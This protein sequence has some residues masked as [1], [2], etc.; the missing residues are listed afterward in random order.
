[1]TSYKPPPSRWKADSALAIVALVWGSTF[2]IVKHAL[3]DIS[4]M[5]FLALRFALAA[6]CML[7]IFARPFQRATQGAVLRGLRGGA[8]AGIFLWL[9]YVLQTVGLK[10]TTAGNSGFL[11]GLYIVLV[12]LIS[13]AVYRRW[14]QPRE[15][16]GIAIATGGMAVLT[17]PSAGHTFQLNRGD[18]LTLGCAV[19]FAFHL[20]VLGYYSQ[21]ELFQAVAL[22]QISCAALLSTVSMTFEPPRAAWHGGVIFA[23]IVTAV[24][25]TALAFAL[26]TWGQKYTTP[27]RTALIFA[28]EPVFALVTAVL[29][30]HEPLTTAAVVGGALILTSILAVELKGAGDADPGEKEE[31]V[32][33]ASMEGNG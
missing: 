19:A 4:T 9:G 21:R 20:L 15:L 23:I 18:L 31:A 22:G 17:L 33:T 5:Y 11:T 32:A 7:L 28:L 30:G 13:A 6:L 14:P 1:M 24:F 8:V 16:I 2:V 26:Q 10:Y 27:T 25:A 3:I 29:V 12:P